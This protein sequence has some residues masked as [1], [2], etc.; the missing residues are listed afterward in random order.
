[1]ADS[2]TD[3]IPLPRHTLATPVPTVAASRRKRT[4][5][6]R[7]HRRKRAKPATP[8]QPPDEDDLLF[9]SI[10][11]STDT[12]VAL[13]SL[14]E[15]WPGQA[16]LDLPNIPP[17]VLQSQLYALVEDRAEVDRE[18]DRLRVH[19]VVRYV[20]IPNAGDC[21]GIVYTADFQHRCVSG[22]DDE[23]AVLKR[24]FEQVFPRFT[25]DCVFQSDIDAVLGA[26][27]D[28]ATLLTRLGLLTAKD[29]ASFWFAV[30]GMG[31]FVE[32]RKAGARETILL[33]KRTQY[34]EMLLK[35]LELRS[36]K[37]SMFTAQWHIR[38]IVGSEQVE[39]VTTSLGTLVRLRG[40]M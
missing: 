9:S 23:R 11:S 29:E 33:L 4:T 20:R 14:R 27:L 6:S 10:V 25:D 12:E 32:H 34:K 24:F 30:P 35:K 2:E 8:D 37:K 26:D 13:A 21:Y 22:T 17:I 18:I 7:F 28:Y 38:D 5:R 19:N 3:D 1:M 39:V 40:N 31:R 36:M 16:A 15:E